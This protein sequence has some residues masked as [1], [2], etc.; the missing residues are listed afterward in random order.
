MVRDKS[1][2]GRSLWAFWGISLLIRHS[3]DLHCIQF[4]IN[5]TMSRCS[6]FFAEALIFPCKFKLSENGELIQ[7]E[8]GFQD[9]LKRVSRRDHNE[10]SAKGPCLAPCSLSKRNRG[11]SAITSNKFDGDSSNCLV[12]AK[13]LTRILL[14]FKCESFSKYQV[15]LVFL[16]RLLLKK[17]VHF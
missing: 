5:P 16:S 12:D 11:V 13:S 14:E 9:V 17:E 4:S 2:K 6:S 1:W 10:A 7:L 3:F 15:K 8:N